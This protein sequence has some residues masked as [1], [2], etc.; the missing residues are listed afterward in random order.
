MK[1]EIKHGSTD[2]QYYNNHAGS[3]NTSGKWFITDFGWVFCLLKDPTF[4][5]L[6]YFG[7]ETFA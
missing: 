1:I 4:E 7:Q 5:E 6:T 3:I 2:P